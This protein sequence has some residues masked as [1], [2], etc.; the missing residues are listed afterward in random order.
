MESGLNTECKWRSGLV[1]RLFYPLALWKSLLQVPH[2]RE[3]GWSHWEMI[4]TSTLSNLWFMSRQFPV[5]GNV[6]QGMTTLLLLN[7]HPVSSALSQV[8]RIAPFW[9]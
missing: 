8:F 4:K 6:Q 7:T 3:G 9:D 2:A 1:C 5:H